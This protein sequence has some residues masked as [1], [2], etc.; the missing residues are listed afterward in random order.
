MSREIGLCIVLKR[1]EVLESLCSSCIFQIFEN[2]EVR[3]CFSCEVQQAMNVIGQ[4]SKQ[5]MMQADPGSPERGACSGSLPGRKE[6]ESMA[7]S[8]DF[9]G[10]L[11]N[12]SKSLILPAVLLCFFIF[13]SAS[14]SPAFAP[15]QA[16]L[17]GPAGNGSND[18]VK[19]TKILSVLKSRTSDR[20]V[21]DKAVDKLS[22]MEERRLRLL[23][24]LC[25]RI[26]EDSDNAGADIA[27]SL[28]TMLIV[29]S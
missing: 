5:N 2:A 11:M 23:S 24:S 9:M 25:D 3:E 8:G 20:T 27:F 6:K 29:L 28:M 12:Y 19:K 22:T 15:A 21:L 14:T 1:R 16:A 4:D 18:V 26:S 7:D 13:G 10:R 17:S